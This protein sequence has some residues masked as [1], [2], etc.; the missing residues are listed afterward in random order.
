MTL[1]IAFVPNSETAALPLIEAVRTVQ[2]AGQLPVQVMARCAAEL[3]SPSTLD[4]FLSFA[5]TSDIIVVHLMGGIDSVPGFSQLLEISKQD[6]VHFHVVGGAG[7][8]K[9]NLS[10][11]STLQPVEQARL[12]AYVR[13]GG[14][15]NFHSMLL[16]L[17]S[18]LKG[19]QVAAPE[20]Q[21]MPWD[22]IYHPDFPAPPAP[23]KYHRQ[24]LLPGR[25]TIGI[26]FFRSYWANSNLAHIDA[27]IR[28]VE[29]IGANVLPIFTN[30][31]AD[32][33]LGARGVGPAIEDYF[34]Q[35]EV[36]LIDVLI[37]TMMLFSIGWRTLS[38]D[39]S[40][41]EPTVLERLG[42]PVID[43][44]TTSN[45]VEQWA[46]SVQGLNPMDVAWSVAIPE[47]DGAL[48]TVPFAARRVEEVDVRTGARVV[49]HTPIPERVEKVV[50]LAMNWA[51]L[52]RVP[53]AEKR[54]A[55][56][57]HNYPPRN[58]TIGTAFGLDA[59]ASVVNLLRALKQQGYHV[60][61]VPEKGDDLIGELL[62][63]VTNNRRWLSAE[64]AKL[65]VDA[66]EPNRYA[67]WFGALSPSIQAKLVEDWGEIPGEVF[68]YGGRLCIPGILNG[69]VFIGIQP[70]RGFSDDPGKIYHSPDASP[71]HH[72]LAYYRWIRDVFGAHVVMHIGKHGSLEWLPG[73]SVGLSADCFPDVMVDDLPN[74]YPYI[75]NNPSEGTQAKRRSYACIVDHLIPSM[76]R[77][78]SYGDIAAV[79][80]LLKD[81]YQT[82]H[83]DPRKL[84][85]LRDLLWEAVVKANLHSDLQVGGKPADGE[86]DTFLERLHGYL[87][88]LEGAPIKDGLHV[89][90]EAPQ[91]DRL[92][93]FLVALTRL[94][95]G[96]VPSLVHALA[97]TLG[98]DYDG[99][100]E[101][102]GKLLADQS[103]TRGELLAEIEQAA[104]DLVKRLREVDFK[105]S[106]VH[107]I[108]REALGQT[109]PQLERT[110]S[111]ICETLVP[112]VRDT[113]KEI[114]ATLDACE[115]RY[116]PPGLSGAPTRGMADILPTGRNFYSVDPLAIPSQA[117]WRE[118]TALGNA[119]LEKYIRDTGEYPRGVGMVVW[120]GGVMRTG[121][122]D[123]AEVLYLMGVK[124]EW[125]ARSGRVKGLS[126]IPLRELG[127]P[128]ID[129]TLRISGLLRDAFPNVVALLDRAVRMVA[130]LEE[131]DADNYLRRNVQQEIESKVAEGMDP[132]EAHRLARH[133]VFGCKPGCYGAGVNHAI[134]AK[135]WRDEVDIGAIYLTWGGYAYG[136]EVYGEAV[137][138]QFRLRLSQ[139]DLTV[140]NEDN[141]EHDIL[142]S[143]D[144]YAYHGGMAAAVK[145]FK[146]EL[147]RTYFGDSSDPQRIRVRSLADETKRIFR[148]RVLN[149]KWIASMQR[150][151]YKGAGDMSKLVDHAFGWDA[152]AEVL[153]DWMYDRLAET[154]ALDQAM[155]RW[156]KEVN[157]WALQNIAERLLEAAER[158]MWDASDEM[159]AELRKVYLGVE[160]VLEGRDE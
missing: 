153:E 142:D 85:T 37:D 135:N 131:S 50:R 111:Y 80:T 112:K 124:P 94:D 44:I 156:F 66:V 24:K 47:F 139:L 33:E 40:V 51:R 55:I 125:E 79:D 27:L 13:C 127:R 149:P 56:L 147:P 10:A 20:P 70:P 74:V 42:V 32:G 146:G 92:V 15:S 63:R 107:E 41:K 64:R 43:A 71:T 121:G 59:P 90:G 16:W 81:Y 2:D 57:L 11:M 83:L 26:L 22:G 102:R 123:V 145:A 93:Q 69:N 115:G 160:G 53:S 114:S 54:V 89:L 159:R 128:R 106:T 7:E 134:D 129:V 60:E 96:D 104:A 30:A 58:D 72:Y 101:T 103:K 150:H 86:W 8:G 117:A 88:E 18:L 138:E 98:H 140:K 6:R 3:S 105:D 14:K 31:V 9:E 46:E 34:L 120:G 75:V 36:P 122:D 19:A 68:N 29:G 5:S 45:T 133:R 23:Q 38:P 108:S 100:L 52:R 143:D 12:S 110:L 113:A 87:S 25:L 67:S 82:R 84:P 61:S 118:G 116:V 97:E 39:S 119:L 144:F 48:I 157:P 28:A 126:I 73:K 35:G 95:N 76:M 136:S 4:A 158:G 91:G 78:D 21:E 65:A 109:S 130:D 155:R 62:C 49:R 152:T 151:G 141:R 77:A 148:S 137:P 132:K 1:R 17:A 99:L 154:Y